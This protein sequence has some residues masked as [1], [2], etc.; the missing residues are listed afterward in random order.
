MMSAKTNKTGALF[1]PD[2]S[3]TSEQTPTTA[4]ETGAN[5]SNVV[6]RLPDISDLSE[7]EKANLVKTLALAMQAR[8][9]VEASIN[10]LSTS[11]DS[12]DDWD[13]DSSSTS[14]PRSRM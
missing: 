13:E 4:T 7:N 11:N 12:D 8:K 6:V 14:A 9:D 2:R 10:A 5:R 1:M 3:A